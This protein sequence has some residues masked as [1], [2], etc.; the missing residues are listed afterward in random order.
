MHCRDRS[1]EC[2][3][4]PVAVEDRMACTVAQ[5]DRPYPAAVLPPGVRISQ[6]SSRPSSIR[7]A[8]ELQHHLC[9]RLTFCRPLQADRQPKRVPFQHDIA[10]KASFDEKPAAVARQRAC[11]ATRSAGRR[12]PSR[13]DSPGCNQDGLDDGR[14]AGSGPVW[15]GGMVHR[16]RQSVIWPDGR[17]VRR[18]SGPVRQ[19]SG[20]SASRTRVTGSRR[21]R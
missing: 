4:K 19:S 8:L 2:R 10:G 16:H 7:A 12:T 14:L 18:P 6:Q 11:P 21:A 17:T 1:H 20:I 5:G 9:I 13:L 15:H 3:A